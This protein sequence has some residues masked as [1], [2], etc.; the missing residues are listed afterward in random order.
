MQ[1][2]YPSLLS[3]IR[4]GVY[5]TDT[6][7]RITYWNRAAER[8]TGY[9][10]TEVIGHRCRDNILV[11]VDDE[12]HS[13]CRGRCPLAATMRDLQSREAR[14]FLH[15]KQGHRLPV[16][17]RCAPLTDSEGKLVG[18]AEFFTDISSE[19]AMQIR[20]KELENL[21]LLDTLTQLPNRNHLI[22]E[23]ESRFQEQVRMGLNFGLLF[24]DIDHFKGFNDTY[25]H[26]TGDEVLRTVARTIKAAVR[27]FDLAGR[28][29]GEEFIC[30]VRNVAEERLLM[31]I[32][33][34]L[35]RLI[36]QSTVREGSR[37]LSV[38]VSIGATMAL[39]TDNVEN[40]VKRADRLMYESKENGRDQ[41][42]LG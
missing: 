20:I 3:N 41:V 39:Q 26:D 4:D 38:T 29:G 31:D 1:P 25:G 35:R 13:L 9:G 16:H 12:G 6:D 40:L 23:L 5:F 10:A 28:W 15:H 27:P 37:R 30:I 2:D 24:M 14:V 19:E 34:R 32:G 18:A 8:I 42:T 33:N 22:P 36:A 11:H 7:R 21:A 17:V